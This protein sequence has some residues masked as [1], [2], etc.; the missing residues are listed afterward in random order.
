MLLE[1]KHIILAN[2]NVKLRS[3]P[4][5]FRKVVRQR[6]WGE[7]EVLI[8]ASFLNLAVKNYV[9]IGPLLPM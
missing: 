4:L 5:T 8:Q 2:V 9:K 3:W 7:V 6:I 1:T